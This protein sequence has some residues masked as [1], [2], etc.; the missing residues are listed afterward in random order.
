MYLCSQ[1][2]V[3][4]NLSLNN[5]FDKKPRPITE[6]GKGNYWVV[7]PDRPQGNK[8][9]RKRN[10]KPGKRALAAMA[11]QAEHLASR[12]I[13]EQGGSPSPTAVS[14]PK[15]TSRIPIDPQLTSTTAVFPAALR[16]STGT[17]PANVGSY[18]AVTGALPAPAPLNKQLYRPWGGSGPPSST[19]L[20][21]SASTVTLGSSLRGHHHSEASRPVGSA[22][23]GDTE[24]APHATSV[25]K[26]SPAPTTQPQLGEASPH[27]AFFGSPTRN[28]VV[29]TPLSRKSGSGS[30]EGSSSARGPVR[31]YSMRARR[32]YDPTAAPPGPQNGFAAL[33][34]QI[35]REGTGATGTGGPG[36][37]AREKRD[38]G[39]NRRIHED[40]SESEEDDLP[41]GDDEYRPSQKRRR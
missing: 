10:K 29:P 26:R 27:P 16:G 38:K 5:Q 14:S 39:S 41:S 11:A 22:A 40:E 1:N 23:S 4:H 28:H 7:V 20:R 6:P 12:K 31:S 36:L 18:A 17:L 19:T 21:M 8:R 33:A 35:E 24:L 37:S 34:A 13:D 3:R 25:H 30:T 2:S 32:R 9:E 15:T